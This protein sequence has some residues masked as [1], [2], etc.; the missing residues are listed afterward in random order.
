MPL[1]SVVKAL[2]LFGR[3]LVVMVQAGLFLGK[4]AERALQDPRCDAV[5]V[6]GCGRLRAACSCSTALESLPTA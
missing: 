4:L 6:Y 3:F 1:G 2:F 5:G